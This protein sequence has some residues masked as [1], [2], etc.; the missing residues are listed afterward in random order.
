[1]IDNAVSNGLM[2]DKSSETQYPMED[3]PRNA[4]RPLAFSD[5]MVEPEKLQ[6]YPSFNQES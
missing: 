6:H 4:L 2:I 3:L 5:R 1:M